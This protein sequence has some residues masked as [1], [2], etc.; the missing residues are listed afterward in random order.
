MATRYEDLLEPDY[1]QP[2]RAGLALGEALT[3]V[4]PVRLA[5]TVRYEDLIEPAHTSPEQR[6]L[7]VIKYSPTPHQMREA[8]LR[9]SL[10]GLGGYGGGET[11][12]SVLARVPWLGRIL[13]SGIGQPLTNM[14]MDV[15]ERQ[16]PD[17]TAAGL[18]SGAAVAGEAIPTA[19]GYAG[20][21]MS[22]VPSKTIRETLALSPGKRVSSMYGRPA[23]EAEML[24]ADAAAAA[25]KRALG[26][27]TVG[28]QAVEQ[29]IADFDIAGVVDTKPVK[30]Y[31]LSKIR[32][33]PWRSEG[34]K[35]ANSILERT[36]RDLPD[37][38]RM[39]D[40]DAWITE[41][42]KP[43]SGKIGAID[44]QLPTSVR[45]DIV[46][47]ARRYRDQAMPQAKADYQQASSDLNS[48]KKFRKQV[49]EVQGDP[50][51]GVE[52]IWRRIPRNQSLL[53]IFKRFDEAATRN[54]ID[55]H[56]ADDALQLSRKR[57]WTSDDIFH[58]YLI[59]R[60]AQ[61]F[62]IRPLIAKPALAAAHPT[63]LAAGGAMAAFESAMDPRNNP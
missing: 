18:V 56:F 51:I 15:M 46:R 63:G 10:V 52:A 58:A 30:S 50:K 57:D 16:K 34:Q 17:L 37:N 48:F 2:V 11:G 26:T 45:K 22:G 41:H 60:G 29:K 12:A 21:R 33:E 8:M 35:T 4:K 38:M 42:T 27:K 13:G 54:G 7:D 6:E 40:F 23:P 20:A 53:R 39:E 19:I 36:M 43:I 31:L 62:I 28:R 49:A 55:S 47:Y 3:G 44:Q 1:S 59:L 9:G 61:R 32:P 14:S 24:Q 25:A 5:G